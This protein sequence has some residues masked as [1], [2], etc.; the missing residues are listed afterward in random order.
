ML[1]SYAAIYDHGRIEWLD[2]PP[3]SSVCALWWWRKNHRNSNAGP[4]ALHSR[5]AMCWPH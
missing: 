2:A 3:L 1:R 4:A 5:T